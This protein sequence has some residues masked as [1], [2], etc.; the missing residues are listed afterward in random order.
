MALFT[1]TVDARQCVLR[2]RDGRLHDVLASGRHRRMLR[3]RHV[4]VDLREAVLSLPTQ[5]LPT[6][7]AVTVKV[8]AAVRWS[9]LD[10]VAFVERS[11]D[12]LAIVYLAAQLALRE[13]VSVLT[14]EQLHG[15]ASLAREQL[16]DAVATAAQSVGIGVAEVV[17]KDVILPADIRHAAAELVTA[18]HRGAALLEQA[19]AET[20]ALR[21]LANGAKLLDD[22]PALAQ[23]R[24]VQAAPA[25]AQVVLRVEAQDPTA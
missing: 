12:P 14:I 5:E 11:A 20:A 17:V 2:Y 7:D 18:R 24:L 16:T 19:R 4:R 13:A 8:T 25:G 15:R 9:V 21:S 6:V 22:H 23:L 3:S 1:L 10:P